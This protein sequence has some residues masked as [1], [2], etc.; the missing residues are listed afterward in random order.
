MNAIVS[1]P[2]ISFQQRANAL[3]TVTAFV[4]LSSLITIAFFIALMNAANA[5]P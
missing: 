1:Q 4:T 5:T 2:R 3:L